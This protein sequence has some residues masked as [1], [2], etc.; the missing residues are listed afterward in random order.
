MSEEKS[1]PIAFRA[2]GPLKRPRHEP[3]PEMLASIEKAKQLRP[4]GE[5]SSLPQPFAG[6]RLAPAPTEKGPRLGIDLAKKH[7]APRYLS[8][9]MGLTLGPGAPHLI[10]AAGG[11]GKTI[12]CQWILLALASGRVPLGTGAALVR[13]PMRVLHLDYEQGEPVTP[14]RY[15]R[16]ARVMGLDAAALNH[17]GQISVIVRPE[18]KLHR[19]HRDE[20]RKLMVGHDVLLIDSLR[21]ATASETPNREND[22]AIGD[23]L[24]V[25]AR[26]SQETGCRVIIIHHFGKNGEIRGSSAIEQAADCVWKLY[27]T[28]NADR[29]SDVQAV[30]VR[31]SREVGSLA[32]PFAFTIS[33]V[34]RPRTGELDWGLSLRLRPSKELAARREAQREAQAKAEDETV[35]ARLLRVVTEEPGLTYLELCARMRRGRDTVTRAILDAGGLI[36]VT[37]H[38]DDGA[39]GQPRRTYSIAKAR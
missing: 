3:S 19:D 1:D 32:R 33:D 9:R 5:P 36:T 37:V 29:S 31:A 35:L 10:V 14:K 6:F 21:C 27:G 22:S 18:L 17:A 39:R 30:N 2:I 34:A 13:P 7:G 28:L 20:W 26:L 16:I 4:L 25:A 11:A 23:A 24:D 38:K 8:R 15:E 12:L